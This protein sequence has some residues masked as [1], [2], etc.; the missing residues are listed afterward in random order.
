M[1]KGERIGEISRKTAETDIRLKLNLDGTGQRKIATGTGFF[2][3][4]LDQLA[5]HSLIDLDITAS[6]DL[7]IDDHHL[8]E[9][10]GIALGAALG[11]AL[12]DKRSIRRYGWATVPLDEALVLV[13]IDLS[14]R[15]L[16]VCEIG[17]LDERV[18]N[19]TTQLFPEFFRA[20]A[21]SAGLTLHIRKLCGSNS[22]HVIE[23]AFKA[24]ARALRD[25]VSIDDRVLDIPSTKGVL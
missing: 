15:G 11:Q 19:F 22:H 5:K 14:G 2:D 13:S 6:G 9:D 24:F 10:T 16:L 25:A 23:A 20:L 18:G 3:H 7:H 4:M 17:L 8:V 12:G 1:T 21:S